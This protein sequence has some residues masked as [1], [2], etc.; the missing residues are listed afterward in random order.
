MASCAE[1]GGMAGRC[2]CAADQID[3]LAGDLSAF[4]LL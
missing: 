4:M 1:A 3:K 2:Y